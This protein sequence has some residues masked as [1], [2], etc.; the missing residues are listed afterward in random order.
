[1]LIRLGIKILT[2]SL[3]LNMYKKIIILSSRFLPP[4]Q[5]RT[6]QVAF[7]NL[8]IFLHHLSVNVSIICR[9]QNTL[10]TRWAWFHL[11]CADTLKWNLSYSRKYSVKPAL[12]YSNLLTAMFCIKSARPIRPMSYV[13][14]VSCDV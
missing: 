2:S 12:K 6:N 7:S 5:S 13:L 4:F 9:Y 8:F 3:Y 14:N 11:F 1:M 10:T